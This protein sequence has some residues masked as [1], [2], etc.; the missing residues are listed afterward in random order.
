MPF[1]LSVVVVVVVFH[2]SLFSLTG[3][4]LPSGIG[5][6]GEMCLLSLM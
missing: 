2:C 6:R 1:C 4:L 3:S 5:M